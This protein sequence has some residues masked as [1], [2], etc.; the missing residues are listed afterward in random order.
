MYALM[1]VKG[2]LKSALIPKTGLQ[3]QEQRVLF[4]GKEKED[5]EYL[6]MVGVKHTSKVI[7]FEDPACKERKLEE[8]MKNK[9]KGISDSKAYEAVSAVR[10]QVNRLCGKISALESHICCGTEVVADREF[11]VL[12]ELL[13]MQLLKLDT[14][15]AE[16]QD[17]LQRKTEVTNLL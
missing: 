7:L 14:I 12:S 3:P 2:D 13:M 15:E 6:H 10:E 1:Y 8:L 4:R 11:A 17:K 5:Q 9:N 16:G